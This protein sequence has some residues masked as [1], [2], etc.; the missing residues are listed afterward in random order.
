MKTSAPQLSVI[1]VTRDGLDSLALPIPGLLQQTIAADIELLL[2]APVGVV[3]GAT[4]EGLAGLHSV[5]VL[6]VGKVSNRGREAA[7]AVAEA[8]APFI[9]LHENHTRADSQTFERMI[10]AHAARTAA[11]GPMMC[12]ANPENPWGLA[13]YALCYGHCAPPA[14][15]RPRTMLPNHN[16]VYRTEVLRRFGSSLPDRLM[17]ENA[18]HG[19]LVDEGYDLRIAPDTRIWH[20]NESRPGRVLG[21]SFYLGRAYG[22][23][24]SAEWSLRRKCLY[25][26]AWPAV[27][28][29]TATRFIRALHHTFGAS[30]ELPPAVLPAFLAASAHAAGEIRGYFTQEVPIDEEIELHEFHIAGRLGGRSPAAPWLAQAV[31]QLPKHLP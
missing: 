3:T 16:S 25:A 14:H 24:R 30:G 22:C 31:Q 13:M 27:A 8:R 10:A 4:L 18:L 12:A 11:T 20:V 6:E 29:L 5:R 23:A 17:R 7:I 1:L 9:A 15:S 21:D 2:V 28:A 19:E 26:A